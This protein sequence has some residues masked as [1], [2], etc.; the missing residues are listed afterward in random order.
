MYS[1]LIFNSEFPD[2]KI[3]IN[4]DDK[5]LIKNIIEKELNLGKRKYII[6]CYDSVFEEYY[7][8]TNDDYPDTCKLKIVTDSKTHPELSAQT[9]S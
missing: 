8:I 1:Y 2:D 3:K 4:T 7:R 6:C 5:N 9:I